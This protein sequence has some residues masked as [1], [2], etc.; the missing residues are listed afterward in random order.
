MNKHSFLL[1]LFLLTDLPIIKTLVIVDPGHIGVLPCIQDHA[2]DHH[3][4]VDRGKT[5]F[6]IDMYFTFLTP[7]ECVCVCVHVYQNPLL[8]AFIVPLGNSAV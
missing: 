1:L 5:L 3:I 6:H 8:H 4:A 7:C 2:P